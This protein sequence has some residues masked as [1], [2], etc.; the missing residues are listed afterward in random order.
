VERLG[1][2]RRYTWDEA[3]AKWLE[4]TSH[5]RTHHDDVLKLR[6][7]KTY[8]GDT[9]LTDVTPKNGAVRYASIARVPVKLIEEFSRAPSAARSSDTND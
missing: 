9:L 6:W 4:E 2:L 3:V 1:E 7:L 8:L 5:K